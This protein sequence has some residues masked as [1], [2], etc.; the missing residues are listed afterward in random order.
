MDNH[1]IDV[2]NIDTRLNNCGCYQHINV[3][4]DEVIHDAFNL[5][6][7]HLSVGKSNIRFRHKRLNTRGNINNIIDSVVHVIN[8]PVA[9]ELAADGFAYH[10]RIVLAYIGLNRQSVA[11]RL[12]K[13]AHIS[14]SHK[15]HVKSS[16]NRGSCK[17]KH[18]HIVLDMLN[19][20]LVSYAE[21]LLFVNYKESQIF[22]LYI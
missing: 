12:L 1:C 10:L 7:F 15:A 4:L 9:G 8:L 17:R 19:L 13:K 11:G 18:I 5:R 2:W 14:Y 22:K 21:A 16:G 3:A 20:F 6:L